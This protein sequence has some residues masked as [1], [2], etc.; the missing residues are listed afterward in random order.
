MLT[1][2]WLAWL[3]WLA[4]PLSR[5]TPTACAVTRH[6]HLHALQ[7]PPHSK[8]Q[9]RPT[10]ACALTRSTESCHSA[11]CS[12][13]LYRLGSAISRVERVTGVCDRRGELEAGSAGWEPMRHLQGQQQPW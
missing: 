6:Q 9:S 11:P 4:P 3:A 13:S 2:T 8:Q 12:T 5:P 10:C 1:E 7:G